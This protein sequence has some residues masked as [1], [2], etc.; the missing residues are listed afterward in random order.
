MAK[1]KV[2]DLLVDTLAAAGVEE[3]TKSQAT[4]SAA[5]RAQLNREAK[6]TKVDLHDTGS[7]SCSYGRLRG[8]FGR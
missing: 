3:F 6:E 7:S 1:K 2:A 4:R 8:G 5:G